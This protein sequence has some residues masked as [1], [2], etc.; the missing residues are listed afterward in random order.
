[1]V[2]FVTHYASHGHDKGLW[3]AVNPVVQICQAAQ[4]LEVIHCVIRLVP[5]SPLQAIMQLSGRFFNL[6]LVLTFAPDARMSVGFPLLLAAWTISETTR[7][8][9]YAVNIYTYVPYLITWARYT[10]F[11]IAYPLG[12]TGELLTLFASLP[13]IKQSPYTKLELPNVGNIS[14]YPEIA[15]YAMVPIFLMAFFNL[16]FYMF[17][18]RRKVLSP[19]SGKPVAKKQ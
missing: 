4:V 15:V 6:F 3:D 17:A 2:R 13:T 5:S 8:I 18:Q 7:Y 16:Y 19:A 14:F 1:M 12:L 11:I 9:Y 10:F